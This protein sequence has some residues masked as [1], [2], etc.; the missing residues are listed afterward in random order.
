MDGNLSAIKEE[1]LR[2]L[3]KGLGAAGTANFLRQFENSAKTFSLTIL[4]TI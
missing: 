2:V 1:G 4:L 3:V